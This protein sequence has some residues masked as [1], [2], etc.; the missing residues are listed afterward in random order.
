MRNLIFSACTLL[1]ILTSNK[2]FAQDD[3]E[4]K[5]MKKLQGAYSLASGEFKGKALSAESIKG[6]SII[7]DKNSYNVKI[8]E[9]TIIGTQKLS[10]G[11]SPKEI[12]A[13][14]TEGPNQ[15]LTLGI[16]KLENGEFTVCFAA[17][18][19]DRPKEFT[20]KSGTGEFMH[21]WKKK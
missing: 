18:G 8:G 7:I 11:K 3:A 4:K 9:T 16:Y 17:P 13:M 10:P 14:G 5:D 20:S 6:A 1:S 2:L 12:D 19:K 15:G 21:I